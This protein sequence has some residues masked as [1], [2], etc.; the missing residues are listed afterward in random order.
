MPM[1][2]VALIVLCLV[3]L[4]ACAEDA[5]PP[6]VQGADVHLAPDTT[7]IRGLVA[8]DSTMDSM[9]RAHGLGAAAVQEVI[10]AARAVFDPRK[11]RTLQPFLLERTLDGALRLFEYEID[12]DSFLR[13]ARAPDVGRRPARGSA[14][15]TQDAGAWRPR[16]ARSTRRHRPCFSPSTQRVKGPT[17]RSPWPRCLPA[18]STSTPI[19]SL[20]IATRSASSGSHAKAVRPRTA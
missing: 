7:E 16:P 14:A 19:S 10:A 12:A 1:P 11:L 9:L 13:I 4:S 5:P 18:R 3:C 8:D 2:R 17:W 15:D 20:A 6:R